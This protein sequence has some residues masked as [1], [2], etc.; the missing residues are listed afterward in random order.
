MWRII[1]STTLFQSYLECCRLS[2]LQLYPNH[3]LNVIYYWQ[4]F[5][6]CCL[7]FSCPELGLKMDS[8]LALKSTS[9]DHNVNIRLH[10]IVMNSILRLFSC[11]ANSVWT[12]T[13]TYS[14]FVLVKQLLGHVLLGVSHHYNF[15][16][17]WILCSQMFSCLVAK[18]P[19]LT[20][21]MSKN[22]SPVRKIALH[23]KA[24]IILCT[25]DVVNHNAGK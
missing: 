4:I 23:V 3:T 8:C 14:Y 20:I 2:N 10:L 22:Y 12:C 18:S 15:T 17:M 1:Q 13:V 24:W 11:T 19:N 7:S 21:S 5:F 6:F 9:I 25:G 16:T